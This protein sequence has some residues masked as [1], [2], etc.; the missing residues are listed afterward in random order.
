LA[1]PFFLTQGL[2]H[3]QETLK[4]FNGIASARITPRT[5]R[6][7]SPALA[8]ERR[9]EPVPGIAAIR[10]RFYDLPA[11]M[12]TLFSAPLNCRAG[13]HGRAGDGVAEILD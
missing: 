11:A 7:S 2:P 5:N 9:G 8:I 1:R 3:Y 12:A 10:C 13:L 4:K 6:L